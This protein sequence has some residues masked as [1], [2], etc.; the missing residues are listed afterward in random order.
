MSGI[1]QS[2]FSKLKAVL[3]SE[4]TG[5]S[6]LHEDF[7]D[8]FF[9]SDQAYQSLRGELE[10][11]GVSEIREESLEEFSKLTNG[12]DYFGIPHEV[13]IRL[14]TITRALE[15]ET[16]IETGVCNGLSTMYL[17]LALRKNGQGH[18][19]S[20]DYPYYAD[21]A[22][23]EFRAETFEGYGGAAIPAD[24]EPGWIVPDELRD[25]WNLR[26]GKSQRELPKLVTEVQ[27]FDV[28][29][30]DS[31]HSLPCM[32]FEYE[33][34]WEW[35]SDNG[36]LLSDDISWNDGFQSFHQSRAGHAGKVHSN[37]GYIVKGDRRR[38]ID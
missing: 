5:D 21:E 25:L 27:Q 19:H 17:L 2:A 35:L 23:D 18:L 7:S 37:V 13:G 34:A 10:D 6:A 26:I 24:K 29:L 9:R 1:L 28:F 11:E 22:L 15:P 3:K 4:E 31:E 38:N 12:R 8:R 20:I 14:Y 30:H 16:V 33:L 32:M 36:V